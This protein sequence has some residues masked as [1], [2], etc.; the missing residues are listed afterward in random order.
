[1]SQDPHAE[2]PEDE[3]FDPDIDPP[4]QREERAEGVESSPEES[5]E[6]DRIRVDDDSEEPESEVEPKEDPYTSLSAEEKESFRS[7]MTVGRRTKTVT[8]F[9]HKVA[10]VSLNVDDEVMIG[11]VSKP[12][13]GSQTFQRV[14]QSATVAAAIRSVDGE[15]WGQSMFADAEPEVLFEQKWEK[16]RR[17][18]PLVVQYLYNEVMNM[19]SEFAELARKL[20]KV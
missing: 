10:L 14:W 2:V 18:Y 8:L 19:E 15:A 7:L 4:K 16:V 11:Q 1:M 3:T 6:P 17:M 12:H 5:S 9:D 20:G 13:V